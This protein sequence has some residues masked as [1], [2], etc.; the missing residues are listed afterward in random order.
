MESMRFD[1]ATDVWSFGVV[2]VE[3]FN[4]GARPYAALTNPAVILHVQAGKRHAAP[5][6][7]PG[8]VYDVMQSCWEVEPLDRPRFSELAVTLD[9]LAHTHVLLTAGSV[10]VPRTR[11]RARPRK[12]QD[13]YVDPAQRGAMSAGPHYEYQDC[14]LGTDDYDMPSPENVQRAKNSQE[15]RFSLEVT[16]DAD[17]DGDGYEMP[18]ADSVQRALESKAKRL[19]AGAPGTG[20]HQG[21]AHSV[22]GAGPGVAD[23][24]QE[25]DE[26]GDILLK[27]FR[28]QLQETVIDSVV[29][30]TYTDPAPG[31]PVGADSDSDDSAG[32]LGD[33][34]SAHE[35]TSA[36]ANTYG[37]EE[38]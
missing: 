30:S 17:D 11:S 2:M 25:Y 33:A 13:G 14:E 34:G 12:G 36:S 31:V 23:A 38:Y 18:S 1:E 7:C 35:Y 16:G 5:S 26:F 28:F 20:A 29:D 6:K 4:N 3:V 22:F 19:S 27:G 8:D 9:T 15:K 32:G 10:V 37:V 21:G 24:H